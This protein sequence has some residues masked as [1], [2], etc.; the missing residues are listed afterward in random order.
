MNKSPR[1]RLLALTVSLAALASTALAGCSALTGGTVSHL[2]FEDRAEAVAQA[3][4]RAFDLIF[5][6]PPY[7]L[8]TEAVEGLLTALAERAVADR[9][10][11]VVERSGRDRDP[12][13]PERFTD[14]WQRGYGETVLHFGAVD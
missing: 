8:P 5:L 9:G 11:V 3:P 4:G 14:T 6:D 7:D 2:I 1:I 12:V 13:W 10:L